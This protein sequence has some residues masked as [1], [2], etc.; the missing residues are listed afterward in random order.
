MATC[1]NVIQYPTDLKR[2]GKYVLKKLDL[3]D[4]M[5]VMMMMM[6]IIIIIIMI[7]VQLQTIYIYVNH[8]FI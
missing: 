4:G 6:M 3:R 1:E 2:T 7:C 5:R 8:H